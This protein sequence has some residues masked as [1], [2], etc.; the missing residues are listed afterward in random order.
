MLESLYIENFAIIDSVQIDFQSGMTVL[1]GETGAGKSII[2]DAIGQLLG[3]RSQP[4]YVK[5]GA[6]Y[7]FIEGVFSSN[8]NIDQILEENNFSIDEQLVVSKK[9]TKEGKSSIKINYRNSNQLMLKKIMSQI[10]DIHSQFETHQ[11]FNQSYH[12]KLLDEYIGDELISLKKEYNKLYQTYKDLNNQY[13]SLTNEELSDEQLDF[14]LSQLNEINEL[15]LDNFN[16]EVF[17]Q[18]RNDLLNYEKNAQHLKEYKEIMDSSNGLTDLFKRGLDELSYFENQDLKQYY[19]QLYDIYY[20]IEGINQEI[21]NQFSQNNYSDERYNEV[22]DIFF[23]LNKLKRKYGQTINSILKFKE[24]LQ[25]KIDTFKNRDFLIEDTKSKLVKIEKEISFYANSISSLRMKKASEFEEEVKKMLNQMYLSH[26]DFKFDF[27]QINFNENG[28]DNV[29]IVVS[30]NVDQPFQPLQKIASGGELSRIMLAIKAA[31]QNN[32]NTSTIIFDEADTG[33]SGKVAES[34]GQ[35]M[36]QI[37]CKQQVI[38]ITHLAQV[39]CFGNNHLF[40]EKNQN[41]DQVNVSVK[42]LNKDESVYELAKMIS[43]KS[44]TQ[45]S[46]DHAKKLKEM[47]A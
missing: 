12:L 11:L 7:A 43:G 45:Q 4:N 1:T 18:E 34:I 25:K 2:I 38:C 8:N 26:V 31:S 28:I 29:K 47:C 35:I 33:V 37:S 46:I 42:N 27:E 39:A 24:N 13:N 44:V 41:M 22:Q 17:L 6:K 14:Y 32:K 19:D 20:S 36:K 16:E 21:Y 3:Q 23:K 9:I 10:V 40:I 30:T 15:D 5:N